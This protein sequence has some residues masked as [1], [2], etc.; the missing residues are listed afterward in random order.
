M[1]LHLPVVFILPLFIACAPTVPIRT[2]PEG[3]GRFHLSGGAI[4]NTDRSASSDISSMPALAFG[5]H[6][7]ISDGATIS[8]EI[9]PLLFLFGTVGGK[10]DLIG[11]INHEHGY[12]PEF[13]ASAHALG[14]IYEGAAI[15]VP[16]IRVNASWSSKHR[17][18]YYVGI[19]N[20]F[21]EYN[22]SFGLTPFAG[23]GLM[24][25]SG[26]GLQLEV[27]MNGN[28][29]PDHNAPKIRFSSVGIFAGV[30]L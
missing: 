11:R 25:E 18:L 15:V 21:H 13:T 6:G 19:E 30:Y 2:L 28:T 27:R 8:G 14:L 16:S 17:V 3:T 4:L 5:Y 26:S 23:I 29:Y 7:A 10:L 9:Y 20:T 22:D 24:K 12:L 1:K